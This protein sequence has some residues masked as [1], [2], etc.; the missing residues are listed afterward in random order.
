MTTPALGWLPLVALALVSCGTGGS[1]LASEAAKDVRKRAETAGYAMAKAGRTSS[2]ADHARRVVGVA[3]G[4]SI[5]VLEVQGDGIRGHVLLRLTSVVEPSGFQSGSRATA[6]FRYDFSDSSNG[7]SPHEVGCGDRQAIALPEP[8]PEP[9]L[10]SDALT[11][12]RTAL[13]SPDPAALMA[14]SF[15]PSGV[16][17]STAEVDGALGAAVAA[18]SN[19]CLFGR[20]TAAGVVEVWV[21]PRVLAQPGELGCSAE[22]AARGAGKEPPH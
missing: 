11:L 20:R 9:R 3:G 21:V 19:G 2:A 1:P 18:G 6:C 15:A 4:D 17:V 22:W 12:L 5:E 14:A 13:D 10:P 7:I 8:S 16:S